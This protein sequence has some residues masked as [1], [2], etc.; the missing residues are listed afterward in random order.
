MKF[1]Y[2]LT[3]PI[4]L[5]W[6]LDNINAIATTI[7][8][9]HRIC[10]ALKT[11]K[12]SYLLTFHTAYEKDLSLSKAHLILLNIVPALNL[13]PLVVGLWRHFNYRVVPSMG[14]LGTT[15]QI[16]KRGRP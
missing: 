7:P 15:L 13:K 4:N 16:K 12:A 2:T 5:R 8:I 11:S 3:F 1:D 6:G 9:Y 10:I 14:M